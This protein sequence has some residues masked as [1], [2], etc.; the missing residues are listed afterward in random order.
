MGNGEACCRACMHACMM[1]HMRSTQS[2]APLGSSWRL[3]A[4]SS[5]EGS[6]CRGMHAR[7]ARR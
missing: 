2:T 7:Q 1:C 6:P 5:D 4:P 3:P